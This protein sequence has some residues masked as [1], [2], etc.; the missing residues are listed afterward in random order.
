[1][2][3]SLGRICTL[4]LIASMSVLC[5]ARPEPATA[6]VRSLDAALPP[7]GTTM[8]EIDGRFVTVKV[9]LKRVI[10]GIPG[11]AKVTTASVDVSI[12][13]GALLPDGLRAT[14]VRFEKLRGTD[15]GFYA[16]L[17]SVQPSRSDFEL[18][19][20]SYQSDISASAPAAQRLKATVRLE[21]NGRVI[22]VPL[23]IVPV[24]TIALP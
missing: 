10:P 7:P 14:R 21:M 19:I 12:Q 23:G 20:D 4:A 8:V 2:R 22:R 3:T 15:R 18:D 13:D 11:A 17:T 5:L 6:A 16:P 1:M 9:S 24:E